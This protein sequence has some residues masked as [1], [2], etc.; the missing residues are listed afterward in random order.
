VT[1]F[2]DVAL[3]FPTVLFSF[4]L[5]VVTGYWVLVLF[6][7]S[8]VDGPDG[9]ADTDVDGAGSGGFAGLLTA[10]GL[11][12]VPVTVVL[13]VLIALAWFVSLAGTALLDDAGT[14]GTVPVVLSFAVLAAALAVAW[15]GTRLMVLGVRRML[16]RG[17]EPSR[18]DF[19][20]R[21]C[22]I[23]TGQVS[24]DFGQAEVTAPDGSSA[25]VQVRQAG[26]DPLRAGSVALIY[27]FDV[28]GEFFWVMPADAVLGPESPTHGQRD[29]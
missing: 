21:L 11:G 22:V 20:G 12:G 1:E 23:R 16:P 3:R 7:G 18:H 2:V 26:A 14:A 6:G 24:A 9:D 5:V 28:D 4:L 8:D 27:D 13:S 17:A 10:A 19:V 25:V 15:L 29:L